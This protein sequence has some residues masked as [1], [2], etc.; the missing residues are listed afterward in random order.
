MFKILSILAVVEPGDNFV[1][2][3]FRWSY[4]SDYLPGF[5]LVQS[6]LTD[7]GLP[8]RGIVNLTYFSG[9][10]N[11]DKGC[12]PDINFRRSLFNL[13]LIKEIDILP[14]AQRNDINFNEID[15]TKLPD[16]WKNFLISPVKQK[17][18]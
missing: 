7:E 15:T 16:Q 6:W 10:G 4:E 8:N 9:N 12:K 13:V 3:S 5:E 1:D 14:E 17:K 18:T 2:K 11:G